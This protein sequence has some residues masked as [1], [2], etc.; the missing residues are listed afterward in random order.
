MLQIAA[1]KCRSPR[2][3]SLI[4][5]PTRHAKRSYNVGAFC[6]LE[7]DKECRWILPHREQRRQLLLTPRQ[8]RTYFTNGDQIKKSDPYH[9]LGLSWGDGATSAEIRQAFRKKASEL[10]P[11]VNKD[12][13]PEQALKKFQEIQRAYE[14]LMKSVTA[15][16]TVGGINA[17]EWSVAIWRQ[18]DRIALDRTDV[19]GQLRQRPAQAVSSASKKHFGNLLGHPSG[20]GIVQTTTR[21]EYLSDGKRNGDEKRRPSSVG[22]GVNKWVKPKKFEPWQS[23][24]DSSSSSTTSSKK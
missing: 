23:F 21:G 1:S 16:S 13:T 22:R 18:G 14:T 9:V 20:K 11:D 5:T 8:R 12:D 17:E 15:D 2:V 19:A 7:G 4:R 10:H 6:C 3:A 24:S